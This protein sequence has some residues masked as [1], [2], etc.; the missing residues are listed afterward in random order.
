MGVLLVLLLGYPVWLPW[1]VKPVASAYGLQFENYTR[2]GYA[3]IELTNIHWSRGSITIRAERLGIQTPHR[4]LWAR[5]TGAATADTQ[6]IVQGWRVQS[7]PSGPPS[8][9]GMGSTAELLDEL[10]RKLPP[11]FGWMHS[12][13]LTNGQI[14][15]PGN[16]FDVSSVTL[17]QELLTVDAFDVCVR[18]DLTALASASLDLVVSNEQARADVEL[19]RE[20]ARWVFGGGALWESN[21]L[22]LNGWFD[23]ETW[24]PAV[25]S[26]GSDSLR[27]P[28]AL[29]ELGAFDDLRGSAHAAWANGVYEFNLDLANRPEADSGWRPDR[30][31]L[32]VVG[33]GDLEAV[34]I[35]QLEL[36]S[37][38]AT[39]S[40]E[41]PLTVD[42]S[43]N[44]RQ[45][46]TTLRLWTD[47][48]RIEAVPLSGM[49]S[50]HIT[51]QPVIHALFEG[52]F[53]LHGDDVRGF[54]VA[55][56][57][58]DVSG[59]LTWPNLNLTA[60][61]ATFPFGGSLT[62][63][64]TLDLSERRLHALQ[65]RFE[66]TELDSLPEPFQ[67]ESIHANGFASGVWP[68]LSHTG[69]VEVAGIAA[70]AF[71]AA[72]ADMSWA[73]HELWM[74]RMDVQL[75][76]GSSSLEL[77]GQGGVVTGDAVVKATLE[78]D[79]FD[80]LTPDGEWKLKAPWR[81]GLERST[82]ALVLDLSP[83]EVVGPESRLA[84]QASVQWPSNGQGRIEMH[85]LRSS[86]FADFITADLPG[87][88]VPEA[89]ATFGWDNSPLVFEIDAHAAWQERSNALWSVTC[90]AKSNGDS[91][92]FD[93]VEIELNAA[94]AVMLT[95]QLPLRIEPVDDFQLRESL[96]N[97]TAALSLQVIEKGPLWTR[98]EQVAGLTIESPSLSFQ[99]HGEMPD[100][101]GRLTFSAAHM[102]LARTNPDSVFVV[103]RL[104]HPH[105]EAVVGLGGLEISQA[106]AS[107]LGQDIEAQL[108]WE[109]A[110]SGWNEWMET[111]RA[112]DLTGV[113]GNV[114]MRDADLAALA[115]LAPSLIAPIGTLD[116]DL[117]LQ[118]GLQVEGHLVLSNAA[119]RYLKPIGALRDITTDL[120]LTGWDATMKRFEA[121]LGGRPVTMDGELSWQ[122]NG[123]RRFDLHL[124]GENLSLVRDPELFV[125]ADLDV[126]LQKALGGVARLS[127]DVGLQHSLLFRD[128]SLLVG[129]DRTRPEQRPP[130]FSIPQPPFGDWQLD[131]RVKG[132][133]FLNV[134]SPA[135]KGE[136]SAGLQLLGTLREPIAVGA[137]TVDSGKILFPFGMVELENGRVDLT[138]EDPY[139]PRLDFRGVG[140]NFGYTITVDLTGAADAPNLTFQS[141]PPLTAQQI[142]LMLS[143][144]EIPRSD[145]SYSSTDK[146]SRVG[147][148][149]GKEFVNRFIGNTA[150]TE[151]LIFRGGED[152]TDEGKPT[153]TLEYRFTDRWSVFGEYN[154]FRD[155]NSGLKF[156]V[157]SR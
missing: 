91:L 138:R 38:M 41:Q 87:F 26:L 45:G 33:G 13:M 82:N 48:G 32:R 1:V 150:A 51:L 8:G 154:R 106:S 74:D 47:L 89:T 17:C 29:V 6:V 56:E 90:H 36:E 121:T 61:H 131:L 76:S 22:D 151:R 62:A 132:D 72:S 113:T 40:L 53:D 85:G 134:I 70:G 114:R 115:G 110:A 4:W 133:R 23:R 28:S 105:V 59:N 117:A 7:H 109:I 143:A 93:P 104:E 128:F 27:L 98:V 37:P 97:P 135:F 116:L 142:L 145:F 157:L 15:L 35:D 68:E 88:S 75:Q 43:G 77:K 148:Y 146:A 101:E 127:G 44:V 155:F 149:I 80:L 111:L 124:T 25:V 34:R 136:V 69:R 139:R 152:I 14:E 107:V 49:L 31:A 94:P 140:L 39:A 12:M 50:G 73:G 92:V 81:F 3:R 66:G 156:K 16:R 60:V 24:V 137:V 57:G 20:D 46:S 9:V 65:W 54:G 30:V 102:A 71:R 52:Q 86:A 147:L 103:P 58:L 108:Q 141:V 130:Y 5:L 18:A 83:L 144:G 129:F 64:L 10:Q 96:A 153:Y 78:F 119:T 21:R 84:L 99:A 126:R 63:N 67:L 11:L 122:S 120:A 118:P 112:R 2:Q 125:R 95:G 55:T 79:V 123:D 42:Y 100:I 19:R